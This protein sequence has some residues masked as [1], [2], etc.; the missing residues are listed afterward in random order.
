[1]HAQSI[2]HCMANRQKKLVPLLRIAT[3]SSPVESPSGVCGG[4][5]N[6]APHAELNEVV[7]N[8]IASFAS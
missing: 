4:S 7:V 3:Y 2:L 6:G 8:F 1:M 5:E